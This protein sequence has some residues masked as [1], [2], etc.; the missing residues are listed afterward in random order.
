MSDDLLR[1]DVSLQAFTADRPRGILTKGDRELLLKEKDYDNKQ[2]VRDA[3]YRL[4]NHMKAALL[5]AHLLSS[6]YSLD[7]CAAVL[8]SVDRELGNEVMFASMT[9]ARSLHQTAINFLWAGLEH[10]GFDEQGRP[11]WETEQG[12]AHMVQRSIHRAVQRSDADGQVL[13]IDVDVDIDIRITREE[14]GA[15]NIVKRVFRGG[16]DFTELLQYLEDEEVSEDDVAAIRAQF[17]ELGLAITLDQY[18]E[19][20]DADLDLPDGDTDADVDE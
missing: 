13:D 1:D 18:L 17:E 8:R 20:V 12:L 14:P 16:G 11:N 5:D 4:R 6:Y 10:G 19:M 7:E 2:Q 9:L 3:R 15:S